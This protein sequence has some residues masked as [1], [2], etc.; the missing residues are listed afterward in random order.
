[1]SVATKIAREKDSDSPV[2]DQINCCMRAVPAS[3]IQK[4]SGRER[5]TQATRI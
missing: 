2:L 4:E 1:M 5:I 3:A